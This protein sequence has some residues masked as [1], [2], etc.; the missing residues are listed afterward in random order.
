MN[1]AVNPAVDLLA[2]L[3]LVLTSIAPI[4][5]AVSGGVDSLTLATAAHRRLGGRATMI[6]A[7]S[8]AVP[9]LATLRV[10]E[11]AASEGWRL[12]ILDAGE[13][14]DPRYVANPVNRCF[15][16]KTNLYGRL[17]EHCGVTATVVSGTNTDDLSDYR[18]GLEAATNFAVRHPFVEVG[19]D[20]DAVRAMARAFGLGSVAELP[21]SPCLSSRVETGISIRPRTLALVEAAETLVASEFGFATVRCRVR[22]DRIVIELDENDL[23]GLTTETNESIVRAVTNLVS[24]HN[25]EQAVSVEAYRRGSAFLHSDAAS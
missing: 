14:D 10:K 6:H 17:V 7:I 9:S 8:P 21:A 11:L 16:C 15:Y 5:V 2:R 20:K 19:A 12:V 18:P 24:A 25:I 3:D 23:S 4:A 22:K 1:P 13:F